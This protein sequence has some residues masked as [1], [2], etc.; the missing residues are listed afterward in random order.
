M[1]TA[2]VRLMID[3]LVVS[4]PSGRVVKQLIE[5]GIT[6][7]NWTVAS[8]SDGTVSAINKIA[9]FY[10]LFEQ[11]PE[12]TLLVEHA[13]DFERAQQE[14]RFGIV[15][16]FQGATPLGRN[17]HLIRIFHRLGIRIIQLTYNEG[18]ALAPGCTEPVDGGLTSLGIQA[19]Q[20]MN[21]VGVVI[22]LSHVGGRASLEA[23]E[24][25]K[26]PCIFS[27]SNP[28][29]LQDNPRNISDDQMRAC[30]RKGG[31]IGLSTFS[32]FVGDTYD[33]RNPN[34]DAYL[35]QMD[36]ALNLVGEDHVAI[37]TDI[38][39]DPTDGVWWRAVQGRL[40]PDISQGMTYD[41][42]NIQGFSHHADFPAV[43][44]A[45]LAHG[46]GEQMVLKILGQNWRRV[47]GEA[48]G[49]K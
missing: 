32:A 8:H 21:R 20:E 25:S 9:Q 41:T 45:M 42:H 38:L 13:R 24:L 15:L 26:A 22:D 3:G 7:C 28:R 47:Y 43:A 33:G 17:P 16:G 49:A 18:N 12:H 10:W 39:V 36:Y 40:Y 34:L 29:A 1:N 48:W 14:G 2:P 11:L 31:V 37:G 46:F 6:G 19:V 27:H 4:P 44:D 30:A 23:I 5:A 35:R